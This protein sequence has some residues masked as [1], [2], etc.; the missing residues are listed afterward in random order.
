MHDA[1]WQTLLETAISAPSPH[2]IQPWRILIRDSHTADLY[3]DRLRLLPDGDKTGNFLIATAG[4]FIEA[5]SIVAANLH[6]QLDARI[7]R[8]AFAAIQSPSNLDRRLIPISRLTLTPN[9]EIRSDWDTALF[10]QRRTSRLAYTAPVS[11]EATQS[12]VRLAHRW[13]QEYLQIDGKSLIEATI[14][15]NIDAVIIDFNDYAYRAEIVKWLRFRDAISRQ[16]RDGLD[17]RCMNLP[18]LNF[19]L[20]SHFPGFARLPIVSKLVHRYYRHTLGTIPTLGILAGDFWQPE[21]ALKAGRF[22]MQFWLEA[23]RHGLYLHPFGNL[24]TND[25]AACW[26]ADTFQ[27]QNIWFAFKI[28]P[29]HQP[30]QSYRHHVSQIL[31]SQSAG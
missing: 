17:Y 19:W 7:D 27:H 3:F 9:P 28:G 4:I 10:R 16:T 25:R 15:R 1:L 31:I 8:S 22:L 29:S 5:L 6:Y 23:T 2:N 30:P 12:L 11:P 20:M 13:Q 18:P 24:V 21:A 26:C 14:D